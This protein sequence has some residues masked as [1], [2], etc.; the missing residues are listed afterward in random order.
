MRKREEVKVYFD[1][2]ESVY[3]SNKKI[4][5]FVY[6]WV[7]SLAI[8][9]IAVLVLFTVAFRVVS[10]S[11]PS[12]KPTLTDG[13]RLFVSAINLN[14]KR[15]DIVVI[16]QPNQLNEP[17]IKRVIAV[18]G[19]TV[20]IDFSEGIVKVNGEVISET[21][22]KEPTTRMF[23]IAFPVTVPEGCVFVMGDNRNNSTDSRSSI[24]GFV[25]TR[26][27]LGKAQF[28]FYPFGEWK[29]D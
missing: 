5:K 10:V 24:V 27:L 25:D 22:I 21:Y 13:D 23:D 1:E 6:S 8:A 20:D 9:L 2:M 4:W 16:T 29:I 12:M 7:D 3:A 18:G 14:Y 28:R 19:E 17:L 15:G 11:G 26:Y